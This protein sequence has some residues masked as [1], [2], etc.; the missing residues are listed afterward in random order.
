MKRVTGI[1]LI[2]LC[3]KVKEPEPL[4][5]GY[6]HSPEVRKRKKDWCTKTKVI[7][8]TRQF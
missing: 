2:S 5:C 1:F 4:Y 6:K 3:S 8:G 7:D